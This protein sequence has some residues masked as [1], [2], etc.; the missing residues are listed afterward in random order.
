[1]QFCSLLFCSFSSLEK[2]YT[3]HNH[4]LPFRPLLFGSFS[5]Q[6]KEFFE[7]SIPFRKDIRSIL[8]LREKKKFFEVFRPRRC[9]VYPLLQSVSSV[10]E[11]ILQFFLF[12]KSTGFPKKE[13]VFKSWK[14]RKVQKKELFSK[15]KWSTDFWLG[16]VQNN[17]LSTSTTEDALSFDE[18]ERDSFF[19]K[20]SFK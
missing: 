9:R 2:E 4:R 16:K 7:V 10:A 6:E 12:L 19:L 3:V 8:F 18:E 15:K 11:C 13:C 14:K 17:A 20:T 1:M 5:S